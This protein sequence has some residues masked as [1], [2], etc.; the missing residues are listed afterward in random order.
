MKSLLLV[1]AGIVIGSIGL[2]I[3]Q[4]YFDTIPAQKDY[5]SFNFTPEEIEFLKQD[6]GG[7]EIKPTEARQ[8]RRN[9]GL[10]TKSVWFSAD[11]LDRYFARWRARNEATGIRIYLAKYDSSN[12]YANFNNPDKMDLRGLHTIFFVPT[13]DSISTVGGKRETYTVDVLESIVYPVNR[14]YSCP[15]Y[16]ESVCKGQ[17][18]E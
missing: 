10:D 5:K 12:H 14:G 4:E 18:Y 17:S 16:P 15:P 6:G 7:E 3:Y 13:R 2:W 1:I 11:T 9:S 8:I